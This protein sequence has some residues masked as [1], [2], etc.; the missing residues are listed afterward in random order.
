M[1]YRTCRSRVTDSI[2]SSIEKN[3]RELNYE[4]EDYP[5]D[6]RDF[7]QLLEQQTAL[8]PRSTCF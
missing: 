3:L 1:L 2:L 8:T 6:D 4:P 5:A 7:H